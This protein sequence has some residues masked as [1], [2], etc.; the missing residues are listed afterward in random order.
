VDARDRLGS[1]GV[2][3]IIVDRARQIR[4]AVTGDREPSP[5]ASE[6]G[7]EIARAF[8]AGRIAD[9]HAMGTQ[10]MQQRT[11]REKFVARWSEASR[12]R[13]PFTGYEVSD[14]GEIELSFIPGLEDVPQEQFAC[15][16]EISFSSPSISLD[17][18]KAFTVG[19]VIL[20]ESGKVRIGAL[21]AR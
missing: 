6:L 15:F 18:K 20:A 17:D 16:L 3:K 8:I 9:I 2:F 21:H 11:P 5:E 1:S 12:D 4:R 10:G 19:A 13:G 7:N 14:A